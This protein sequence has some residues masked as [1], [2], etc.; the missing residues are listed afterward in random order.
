MSP[1]HLMFERINEIAM[2]SNNMGFWTNQVKIYME[3]RQLKAT[4]RRQLI[5]YNHLCD[6]NNSVAIKKY[7]QVFYDASLDDKN[8]GCKIFELNLYV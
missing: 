2:Q 6:L 7:Q 3:R 8:L 1:G 4:I 5:I